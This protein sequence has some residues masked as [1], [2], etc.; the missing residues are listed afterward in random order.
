MAK[1]A[2][3]FEA[4]LI[5][6]QKEIET[7][8]GYPDESGKAP[9][10]ARL[11]EKLDDMRRDVY[12][13]LTTWQKVQVARHPQRPIL[14]DYI[15]LIFQDFMEIHGDRRFGDDPAIVTGM[16]WFHGRPVMIIGHQKGRQ[17]KEKIYRNFGM[18]NPEGYRKALR[19]MRIAEK[20]HRPIFTFVDTEGA[21]PGMDA[22]DRGQAEAIA[23]NIRE[24]SQIDTPI[25]VTVTG[26]GGSGG[27]LGIAIGD[28]ILMMENAIYSVITP[29]GCAAI[30]WRDAGQ[31]EAAASQLKVTA[32]DLF[33]LGLIDKIV[34]EPPGGAHANHA[35][36]ARL[37]DEQLNR[38][39]SA[40]ENMT[41][42][43]RLDARYQKFRRM[44]D[45]GL[46]NM[47]GG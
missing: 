19:V 25:V 20:F 13:K 39:L 22:E 27:A 45:V 1:E 32:S 24:I 28:E 36:A 44:G 4:P 26:V 34:P 29:E 9:E 8:T 6:I 18:A 41:T 11:Q 15:D 30:L 5:E 38:S 12:S 43:E 21:F 40:I 47:A 46:E 23:Y 42:K 33:R 31:A 16:A 7:L 14:L 2:L 3:D 10:I 37:L 35:E 17:T